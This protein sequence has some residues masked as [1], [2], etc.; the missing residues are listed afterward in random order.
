MS[1]SSWQVQMMVFARKEAVSGQLRGARSEERATRT[2]L[3]LS[4]AEQ[5][6]DGRREAFVRHVDGDTGRLEDL[7]FE[8]GLA[9]RRPLVSIALDELDELVEVFRAWPLEQIVHA[10][11]LGRA[12]MLDPV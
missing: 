8:E 1:W 5:T 11:L 6:L 3:Q 7:L 10:R 12:Q 4:F 9:T 2:H